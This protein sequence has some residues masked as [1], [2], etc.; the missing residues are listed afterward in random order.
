MPCCRRVREGLALNPDVLAGTCTWLAD[1]PREE[2]TLS[3]KTLLVSAA[4]VSAP[5]VAIVVFAKSLAALPGGQ[6]DGGNQPLGEI[7]IAYE[8]RPDVAKPLEALGAAVM[9]GAS[10]SSKLRFM[11]F[12]VVA[13]R[14]RCLY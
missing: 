1:V 2:G 14:N 13:S 5:L 10:I 4:A 12:T 6:T 8:K 9:S 3:G 7:G 11:V